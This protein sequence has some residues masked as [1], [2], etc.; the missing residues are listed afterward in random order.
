M[1]IELHPLTQRIL[2]LVAPLCL[3][4]LLS[5]GSEA[6]AATCSYTN[7]NIG[8]EVAAVEGPNSSG[9]Y[10]YLVSTLRCNASGQIVFDS[11][12][13]FSDGYD[14]GWILPANLVSSVQSTFGIAQARLFTSAV[15]PTY[16]RSTDS[17]RATRRLAASRWPVT[18]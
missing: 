17:G 12:S 15:T 9:Q 16:S 13:G 4:L 18:R 14:M 11:G 10:H 2:N 3:A 5:F 6:E 8:M 1:Q 7:F